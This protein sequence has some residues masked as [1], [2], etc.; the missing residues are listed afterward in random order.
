MQTKHHVN[1]MASTFLTELLSWHQLPTVLKLNSERLTTS[2]HLLANALTKWNIDFIPPSHG[3]FLFAKLTK[4]AKNGA[5]EKKFFDRLALA[6]VR[7]GEGRFYKGVEGE[8]GWARM[9]FSI[10]VDVMQTALGRIEGV[11]AEQ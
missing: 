5:E 1:A 10:P 6:G 11:L 2:Y 7:V 3:L 8:F 4:K 9:C